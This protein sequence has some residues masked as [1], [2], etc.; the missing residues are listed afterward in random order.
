MSSI[1]QATVGTPIVIAAPI[2]ANV[3][4][5]PD[6]FLRYRM[7]DVVPAHLQQFISQ[8]E[9]KLQIV[10]PINLILTQSRS[11]RFIIIGIILSVIGSIFEIVA[12]ML[13]L[14]GKLAIAAISCHVLFGIATLAAIILIIYAG[15]AHETI[16][17]RV[18]AKVSELVASY[19]SRGFSF[20][21]NHVKTASKQII[22]LTISVVPTTTFTVPQPAP[23][24]YP[25]AAPTESSYILSV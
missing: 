13:P 12:C 11:G 21:F 2:V 6:G 19:A 8:D 10:D 22:S 24:V 23:V 14:T 15:V 18:D 5:N 1:P 20:R 7:P 9:Y 17:R 3:I 25:T 4:F 16:F